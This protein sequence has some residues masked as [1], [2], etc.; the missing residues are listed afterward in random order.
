MLRSESV[1]RH[2]VA[3]VG[4][5]LHDAL[6]QNCVHADMAVVHEALATFKVLVGRFRGVPTLQVGIEILFSDIIL[7]VLDSTNA[8]FERKRV[9]IETIRDVCVDADTVMSLFINHDASYVGEGFEEEGLEDGS[10]GGARR[11]EQ[12]SAGGTSEAYAT[13]SLGTGRCGAHDDAQRA[14]QR[15]DGGKLEASGG[16][17]VEALV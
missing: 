6:V 10:G 1:D 4:E 13:G 9:V 16:G 15:V 5:S 7:P 11:Q 12:F 2:F 14:G 8:E 17:V 3:T